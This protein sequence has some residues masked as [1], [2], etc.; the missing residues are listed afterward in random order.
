VE[1]APT[2]GWRRIDLR[3]LWAYRELLYILAWRDVKVRYRQTALGIAWVVAQPLVTVVIFT[4]L[5]H[6]VARIQP[7]SRVPYSVF[8]MAGI[9]PWTLFATGVLNTGNSLIGS[10]HLISK[11]YFPRMIVPA[12]ALLSGLVDFAVTLAAVIA[13]MA[14]YGVTPSLSIALLP[15]PILVCIAFTLGVGLW[16][17]SLNVEYRDV[18][19]IVPVIV[20]FWFFAT[21]VVYPLTALTGAPAIAAVLN[22]MTAV[23]TFF[24]NALLGETLDW[25]GLAYSAAAAAVVLVSGAFYFRRTERLFADVL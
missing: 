22:P 4:L 13:L 6:R 20:Q 2:R 14:F 12:A 7:D 10:A 19:I 9:V 8:V 1:I 15:L 25:T 5:F 24:R 23:V 21:P 16:F 11:V 18:R 3:E 17:S